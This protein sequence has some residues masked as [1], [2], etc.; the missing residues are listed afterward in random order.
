MAIECLGCNSR[1]EHHERIA[2][3]VIKL[4]IRVIKLFNPYARSFDR[5]PKPV[6]DYGVL[7]SAVVE[8]V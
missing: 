4:F 3:R 5:F 6:A 1:V 2:F 7:V 8:L